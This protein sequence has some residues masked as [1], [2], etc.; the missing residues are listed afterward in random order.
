MLYLNDRH[1]TDAGYDWGELIDTVEAAVATADRG[2]Y[3]Q[4]VKPYLRFGDTRNRI[5]AMPAYIGGGFRAAGIKWIASFPGN[6]ER[7]LPRA[8]GVIVLNDAD[9]G[10]PEA[11]L[12]GTLPN[13]LRTAAVSGL[14]LRRWL[15]AAGRMRARLRIGIVG[16][17]PIGRAHMDMCDSVLGDACTYALHDR[18]GIDPASIPPERRPRARIVDD[19]RDAYEEA[20]VF[21]TC[22][23][24]D[25]RYIDAPP[26]PGMLLLHVS[27]RDYASDALA[28]VQRVIVDD[29]AEVCREDT[30]IERLHREQGLARSDAI[31]LAAALRAPGDAAFPAGETVLFCP[32][33]M[34]IF[35][36]AVATYI[37]RRAV[38]RGCGDRLD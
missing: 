30:D 15:A 32:M 18:R 23:V 8:H 12:N 28:G 27:L 6:L 10:R 37:V 5:I 14:V 36:M 24:S 4:P 25:R 16:W 38:D 9:S 34:A 35:D 17:G 21:I 31:T 26:R 20:D 29:W 3:A 33:G 13:R 11:I 19:W 1:M 2:D 22:T 7:G